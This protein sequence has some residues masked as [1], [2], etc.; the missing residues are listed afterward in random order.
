MPSR[1]ILA[2]LLTLLAAVP[3]APQPVSITGQ[4]VPELQAFDGAVLQLMTMHSWPGAALAVTR[5]GQLLLARGYGLQDKE[6]NVPVQPDSLFRMASL[7]KTL[8]AVATMKLVEQG[9]I[10]L[11]AKVTVLLPELRTPAGGPPV[12]AR[13]ANITVRNLLEHTG[14]WD[15]SVSPDP[16]FSS[17]AV[18]QAVG[19]PGPP[20][21]QDNL[22]FIANRMLD[23]DPG[24]K[25]VYSNVGYMLLGRIIEKATGT[26]YEA[27]VKE[28]ILAPAGVERMQI[29]K[30]LAGQRLAGEVKYYDYS[31]A[32]QLPSIF[33]TV[34]GNLPRPYGGQFY[35]ETADSLGGW[36]GSAIDMAR[37]VNAIDG[38]RGSPLLTPATVQIMNERPAHVAAGATFFKAKGFNIGLVGG[39]S[40]WS[41]YGSLAGTHTYL[42]RY[43]NGAAIV[44]LVNTRANTANGGDLTE[45]ADMARLLANALTSITAFPAHD[46]FPNFSISGIPVIRAAVHGATFTEG[47]V[48]GSW[49]TING[50]GLSDSERTW[51]GAD[52]VNGQL[53]TSLDDVSVTING[54]RAYI[55]FIKPTQINLQAPEDLTTGPVWV[56][57][58]RKGKLSEVV[59]ATYRVNAPGFFVYSLGGKTWAVGVHLDGIVVGDPAL[60]SGIRGVKPG[61]RVLFYA[62]GLEVSPAGATYSSVVNVRSP[63]K[64]R[65]GQV[66]ATVEFAGWI[67]PGLAQMNTLIPEV[68]DGDH[69]VT[70]EV[71]GAV[72]PESI[73]V[74]VRR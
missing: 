9:K 18:S 64:I 39:A 25:Y 61:D 66:E 49:V 57:V 22:K 48:S 15:S 27:W 63:V 32:P 2:L 16:T 55:Y 43:A 12:D 54:R 47:I 1:A 38:R 59:R 33:P 8:T 20:S 34:P 52:I 24:S 56:Q 72:S 58:T 19:V 30:T 21:F 41:H 23:F 4:A 42:I 67:G 70:I 10:N 37:F 65:I 26:T 53:P 45:E 69:A 51:T 44:L 6:G 3:A 68:P 28:N 35:L 14:G 40:N 7:S 71:N 5:N 60:A 74:P 50:Q 36:V 73:M 13:L 29:G 46:L 17:R 62:T 11:D 31:G